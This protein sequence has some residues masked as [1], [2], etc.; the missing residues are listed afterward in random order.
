MSG[1]ET[2][3]IMDA[4]LEWTQ[5]KLSF[6]LNPTN[7]EETQIR[8][9]A[10]L[11]VINGLNKLGLDVPENINEEEKKLSLILYEAEKAVKDL[12]AL[13][14]ELA[15]LSKEI[16][17]Q[18]PRAQKT[19]ASQRK[20][21]ASKKLRVVFPDGTIFSE[22]VASDTFIKTLQKIGLEK[23]SRMSSVS[24]VST[25][26]HK[27]T[28]NERAIDGYFVQTHSNTA[29]KAKTIKKLS[30]ILQINLSVDLLEK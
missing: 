30:E 1:Y 3:E 4:L 5:K 25:E 13:S 15:S 6:V 19:Q 20:R 26:E 2:S 28:L 18:L 11:N 7:L 23:L 14:K 24:F 8:Y 9:D 27:G 12:R 21:S 16:A 29:Q 10:T 22:P 17:K